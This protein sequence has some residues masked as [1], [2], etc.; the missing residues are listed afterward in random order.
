MDT[1]VAQKSTR[2]RRIAKLALLT[3]PLWLTVV[4][5]IAIE[6]SVYQAWVGG[7]DLTIHVSSESGPLRVVQCTAYSKL[8]PVEAEYIVATWPESQRTIHTVKAD[9]FLGQALKLC[10]QMDGRTSPFGR[11]L[12]QSQFR[13]LLVIGQLWDGRIVSNVVDIP[14]PRTS[15]EIRIALS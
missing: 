13:Q 11:D 9:P 2:R 4:A 1:F 7:Y 5:A 12:G 10:V 8:D 14:D 6:F 3:S 15:R